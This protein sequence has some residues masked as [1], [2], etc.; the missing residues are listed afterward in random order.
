MSD[1]NDHDDE[2]VVL[3]RA[4]DAIVAHSIFPVLAELGPPKRLAMAPRVLTPL[5]AVTQEDE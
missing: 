1:P 3:D 4:D 5:D 2:T